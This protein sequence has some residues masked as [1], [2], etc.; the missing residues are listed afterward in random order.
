M[1]FSKKVDLTQSG[2]C[3]YK[4]AKAVID[5]FSAF[6]RYVDAFSIKPNFSTDAANTTCGGYCMTFLILCVT[7][8]LA[9]MTMINMQNNTFEIME[10]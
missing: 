9:V 8:L 1:N 4:S 3:L 5:F 6:F 10:S 7:I 2:N